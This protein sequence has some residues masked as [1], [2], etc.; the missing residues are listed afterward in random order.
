MGADGIRDELLMLGLKCGGTALERAKRLLN[1]SSSGALA[2]DSPT[3]SNNGVEGAVIGERV[4][5]EGL[6]G[7]IMEKVLT[8]ERRSTALNIE[9]KQSLSWFELEAERLAEEALAERGTFVANGRD[10]EG[11]EETEQPVYNPKV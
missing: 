3:R 7:H 10:Q 11:E 4:V 6:I 2:P 9:K 8:E 5:I 1:A